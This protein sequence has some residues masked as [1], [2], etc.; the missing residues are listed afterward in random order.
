MRGN[1]VIDPVR[2]FLV[3]CLCVYQVVNTITLLAFPISQKLRL[4]RNIPPELVPLGVVLA[5]GFPFTAPLHHPSTH[6]GITCS[7]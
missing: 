7:C 4:L 6:L 2:M 1:E 5:Y 3:Q